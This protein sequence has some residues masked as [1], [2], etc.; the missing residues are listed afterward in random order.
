MINIEEYMSQY[1]TY[2]K[3]VTLNTMKYFI[4]DKYNDFQK[5]M[6]FIHITGT[7]GKGSTVETISN[8]LMKQGYNVGTFI[9]PHLIKFNERIKINNKEISD[10]E[11]FNLTDELEPQIKEYQEK[12]E[13]KVTFFDLLTIIALLYFYRNNVDFVVLEVGMR[14]N[15]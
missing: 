15:I 8:I 5:N 12:T 10:K 3:D 14:R 6:K 2:S 4:K 9:S 7:N 1:Y 13:N 11:F